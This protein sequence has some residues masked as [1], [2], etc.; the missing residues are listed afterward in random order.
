VLK[1]SILLFQGKIYDVFLSFR[2]ED[3]RAKF[4]SHLYTTLENAG[5]YVFRDDDE[6]QRGDHISVSLLRA[7]GKSRISVVVLSR[8]YANSRWC[9]LELENIM[10][11][12]RT[13]GMV[14]VPVFYE[15]DPS[16]VRHQ[17]RKFGEDFESLLSKMSVDTPKLSNWKTA[18]AEVG[19]TA[20]I[21]IIN[22]R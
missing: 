13:Q 10:Y 2:G 9:M 5:I 6:I 7:I 3:T 18:L 14:V 4:I 21:V 12:S 20:G 16:E 17:T 19:G 8:N 22:S 1:Y 15:I 11:I